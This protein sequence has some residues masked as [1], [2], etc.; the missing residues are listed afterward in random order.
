[1]CPKCS[2]EIVPAAIAS[3]KEVNIGNDKFHVKSTFK[4]LG[5]TI[6]HCGGCSDA[7]STRIVSSWKAF[8]ELSPILTNRAIQTKLRGNVYNMCVRKVL[9][10]SNK[11]WQV[12][13]EDGQW[14]VIADSGMIRWICGVSLKGRIPTTDLL[15][16]LGLSSINEM[17]RWNQLRFHGHL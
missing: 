12:L 4:Y 9:L 17:L 2:R 13:T 7:V 10:Y 3:L 5:D 14:L 6:S 11:T 8:W 15:L 1:M 16:H